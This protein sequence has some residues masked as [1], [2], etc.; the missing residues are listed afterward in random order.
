M[1]SRVAT[2]AMSEQM[3]NSAMRAQSTMANEQLQE[4]SGQ[5][6]PD[7]GG[8]GSTS[9]QVINLQ[10]SVTR[11]QSYIDGSTSANSKVQVMD[12]A[13]TSVTDVLTQLRSLLTGASDSATTNA[14][15]VTQSAQQ[16]MQEFSSL[17]NTQYAGEYVFGGSRTT[18]PPVDVSSAAYPAMTSPSSASTSYYQGD[19]QAASVRVSDTESVSYGVTADN[20]A[21][22]QGLRALN[23]VANNSPLSTATLD[24]ALNL[25]SS[26]LDAATVVQAHLGLASSSI[27]SASTEQASYQNYAKTLGSDLTSVDVAS[28][29]A[30]LSTYQAQLTASYSAISKIQSLNLASYLH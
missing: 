26:A 14:A 9:Q 4:A 7:Y 12:S 29:T 28:V 5:I 8:L 11:S 22:E 30:Q 16:M 24:E 6:S 19:D 13:V 17:L 1:I 23:L 21:F 27:E 15:S 18:A 20:P 3:I 10:V 2:F 25:A